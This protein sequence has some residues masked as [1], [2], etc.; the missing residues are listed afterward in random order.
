MVLW[1]LCLKFLKTFAKD[2]PAFKPATLL[3]KPNPSQLFYK[4]FDSK[5]QNTF[6][7][8]TPLS[9][10]NALQVLF[11]KK[12][13]FWQKLNGTVKFFYLI[14]YLTWLLFPGIFVLGLGSATPRYGRL[15]IIPLTKK[16]VNLSF[17]L[18]C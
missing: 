17:S 8:R 10:S 16:V 6:I 13:I 1:N 3:K 18:L 15:S 14:G 2:L 11:E 7:R 4:Y 9:Y 5:F 12:A